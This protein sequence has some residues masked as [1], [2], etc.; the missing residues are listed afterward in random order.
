[1]TYLEDAYIFAQHIVIALDCL[2]ECKAMNRIF[3]GEHKHEYK[4]A[5]HFYR[6]AHQAM[7]Y[8]FQME[9]AKLFDDDNKAK[10]FD[11][12]KNLLFKNNV[13]SSSLSAEYKT[14]KKQADASLCEIKNLRNKI[15]AHSDKEFFNTHDT[16]AE[17][18]QYDID[19]I[20]KLLK[21]MLCIC[22]HV[23]LKFT[24]EAPAPLFSVYNN[25]DFVKLFGYTTEA[26]RELERWLATDRNIE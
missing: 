12:Y 17:Q 18:H 4:K 23:I 9:V 25:D 2:G 3:T 14:L 5:P 16:F 1:M 10:T 26:E 20:E 19:A 13:L 11:E 15:L 6:T 7:I 8:R 24:K 22:N 21:N